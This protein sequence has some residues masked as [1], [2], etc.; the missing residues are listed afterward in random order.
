MKLLII[1]ALL[2]AA[3]LPCS[4]QSPQALLGKP[5]PSFTVESGDGR[6]LTLD[7]LKGRVAVLFYETKETSRKNSDVK[8]RLNDLYDRQDKETRQSIVRVPVFNCSRAFWPISLVWKQSLRT[9]SKRVGMTLY[10]DWDGLMGRDYQ[11][12]DNES[13]VVLI[14]RRGTIRYASYG[15]ITDRQFAEIEEFLDRLVNQE[16]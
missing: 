10:G 13:N 11:M 5:A 6:R 16:N 14:D 4:A 9:H 12:K 1:A 2:A 15:R 7:M 3:A 8:D